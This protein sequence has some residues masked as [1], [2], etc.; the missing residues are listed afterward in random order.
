M[1]TRNQVKVKLKLAGSPG[2]SWLLVDLLEIIDC[3]LHGEC[4]QSAEEYGLLAREL[5][6]TVKA[7]YKNELKG[8]EVAVHQMDL[9]ALI[10]QIKTEE[11]YKEAKEKYN[12][13]LN[14]LQ[15]E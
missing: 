11:I 1:G 10:E 9:E 7:R 2:I 8:E 14:K 4:E 15:D 13:T 12:E 3:E 5:L 6:K